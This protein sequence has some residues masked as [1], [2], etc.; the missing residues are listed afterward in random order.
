MIEVEVFHVFGTSDEHRQLVVQLARSARPVEPRRPIVQ[1]IS[2]ISQVREHLVGADAI[3]HVL[4]GPRYATVSLPDD[5]YAGWHWK[6]S[7]G[8][9]TSA[10]IQN[11]PQSEDEAR[12]E[13][14]LH[15]E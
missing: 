5:D 9:E 3:G 14:Q 6:C 15:L 1:D 10:W 2:D 8:A 12:E 7:C 4:I 11:W 13:W